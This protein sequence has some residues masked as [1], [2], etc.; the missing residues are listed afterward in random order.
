MAPSRGTGRP[1]QCAAPEGGLTQQLAFSLKAVS[2]DGPNRVPDST[3]T[4]RS[5]LAR[6]TSAA[7]QRTEVPGHLSQVLVA[8]SVG[9]VA[10]LCA[11]TASVAKIQQ[12]LVEMS[13]RL[14][15]DAW[16][17]AIESR[18]PARRDRART[19]TGA[20]QD[21]TELPPLRSR[22]QG[23]PPAGNLAIGPLRDNHAVSGK[24]RTAQEQPHSQHEQDRKY[25]G[26]PQRHR[27][28]QRG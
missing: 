11:L 17:I 6:I 15:R 21:S 10:H 14:A 9:Q 5:H 23:M 4:R 28:E 18:C 20:V 25:R 16:V 2:A 22:R 8:L 19:P 3:G 7:P 24:T 13:G 27:E 12:L 26:Q 1:T